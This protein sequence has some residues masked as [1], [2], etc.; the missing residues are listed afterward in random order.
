MRRR[1]FIAGLGGAVA[2]PLGT[3]A[4]RT[5]L[6]LV[7]YLSGNRESA[8]QGLTA[9]FR[10]GLTETGFVEGRN[11]AILY[12]YAESQYGRLPALAGDLVS[13]RVAVIVAI[14][15]AGGKVGDRYNSDCICLRG[16][17]STSRTRCE[18]QPS[19]WQYHWGYLS[20]YRAN[21]KAS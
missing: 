18:S 16:R 4:E 12:R 6:P 13:R 3:R 5:A 8:I 10:S 14:P 20:F 21:R 17:S 9:A 19:R 7:G 1:E 11:V 2:W 15:A